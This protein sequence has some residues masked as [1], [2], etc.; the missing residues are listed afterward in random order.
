LPG[1]FHRNKNVP[2]RFMCDHK[3]MDCTCAGKDALL[4]VHSLY[5]IDPDD[6]IECLH[7]T[8]F[9][10]AVAVTHY[11]P[12]AHG[13]LCHGELE[14][15]VTVAGMVSCGATGNPDPYIHPNPT[16][17]LRGQT[18]LI[19]KSGRAMTW[20]LSTK[21][22]DTYVIEFKICMGALPA[23]PRPA[24]AIPFL[25]ALRD[26]NY[27]GEV[28]F[29][30]LNTAP[31]VFPEQAR[32]FVIPE[33]GFR[34]MS[35][36]KQLGLVDVGCERVVRVDKNVVAKVRTYMSGRP[37][38]ADTYNSAYQYAKGVFRNLNMSAE[39]VAAQIN[40]AALLGY[41]SGLDD[42]MAALTALRGHDEKIDFHRR[43]RIGN[44]IAD[45][46]CG[47]SALEPTSAPACPSSWPSAAS[48]SIARPWLA[49]VCRPRVPSP[50][51]AITAW[52]SGSPT[53][54]STLG[55]SC[56]P[57]WLSRYASTD[58]PS[59]NASAPPPAGDSTA[60]LPT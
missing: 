29:D 59:A 12:D 22:G 16:W 36:G 7:R 38:N 4:Y 1:D 31:E 18:F 25:D 49:P 9:G 43:L 37:R 35:M 6:F 5:Y 51:W 41:V 50:V 53:G 26:E 58:R 19:A 60:L 54:F 28:V 23:Q 55:Q 13:M 46:R 39:E 15:Y 33:G 27:W 3:L 34:L 56:S 47:S 45:A 8:R 21:L 10:Y 40:W 20:N 11:F 14:Y 42:E 30:P 48:N 52:I 2:A 24:S 17:L 57:Q 32:H 44:P